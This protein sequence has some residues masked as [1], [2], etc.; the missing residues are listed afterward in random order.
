VFPII[1]VVSA[2]VSGTALL[3]A[4]YVIK[5]KA[6]KKPI[7]TQMVVSLAKMMAAFLLV[8]LL[9]Q[10]YDLLVDWYSLS[11]TSL[12]SFGTMMGSVYSWSYSVV[13]MGIGEVVPI[14]LLFFKK[15]SH[16][17]N[18]LLIAAIS[19]VIGIIGVR[20]NIVVPYQIIQIMEGFP[21][22]NYFPTIR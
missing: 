5:N 6:M 4:I 14:F 15:T 2:M 11:E 3:L 21:A 7:D 10:F 1:F 8:D 19:V 12:Q 22:S 20:F 16:N 9:L 17:I 18:A 13:Q